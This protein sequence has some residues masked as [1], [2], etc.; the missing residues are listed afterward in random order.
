MSKINQHK[1]I[2]DLSK[3]Q[4]RIIEDHEVDRYNALMCQNHYL[5]NARFA[6]QSI[7]YV[8]EIDGEWIALCT[9]SAAS[10]QI[11]SRDEIIGWSARQRA[12]RLGLI[13]N[14]SRFLILPNG[15]ST[16][17]LASKVLSL[18][19]KRLSTDWINRWGHPVLLVETYVDPEKFEG[20]CYK[21][22]GFEEVGLSKG[23]GRCSR[24]LFSEHGHPKRLYLRK[25]RKD[26]YK[27]L[28]KSKLPEDLEEYESEVSGPC[29]IRCKELNS[30]LDRFNELNDR[31]RGHGLRHHQPYVLSCAAIAILMGA[32]GYA[33]IEDTCHKFTQA[34]LRSLGALKGKDGGYRPPS[35]STFY[36]VLRS[37]DVQ[38]F[39]KI[40][41][42]WLLEQEISTMESLAIDGKVLRGS[43][44]TDGKPLILLSAVTH[45]LRF[46][47]NQVTIKEK[48]NEIPALPELLRSIGPMEGSLITADAMHCQQESARIVLEEFKGDYIFGLKGN[49]S[50][51]LESAELY[52]SEADFPP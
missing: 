37:V 21:G 40:I 9:F 1:N 38:N 49:Q 43:G 3:V 36:R 26:A 47:L 27:I 45:R 13:V 29:P 32:G 12:R 39:D 11:K 24:D 18:C 16:P 42:E 4:V 28:R 44:R 51:I 52:F 6:G 35:D 19:L 7:R 50:G 17:N 34:Q 41:G 22:C 23:Y 46:T 31:R 48:S 10:L 5:R 30:L 8:A 15:D 33:S 20:T 25:L 14:N 2:Y